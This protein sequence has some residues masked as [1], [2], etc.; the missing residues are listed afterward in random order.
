MDRRA[1]YKTGALAGLTAGLPATPARADVPEHLWAGNDFGFRL[2]VPDRLNQGPFPIDGDR[3][4]EY[5]TPSDEPVRNYGL[6]LPYPL[7]V[8][9]AAAGL[10]RLTRGRGFAVASGSHPGWFSDGRP[11]GWGT[12]CLSLRFPP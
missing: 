10:E 3:T 2:T 5:T 1:F 6:G 8:D 11:R 12:A 9:L 7:L 4:I